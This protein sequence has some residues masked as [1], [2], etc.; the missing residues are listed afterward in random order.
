MKTF[1]GHLIKQIRMLLAGILFGLLIISTQL[2]KL[3]TQQPHN[4][5]S[6]LNQ[7]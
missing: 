4:V 6:A 5:E 7:G 1:S 3:F 2:G